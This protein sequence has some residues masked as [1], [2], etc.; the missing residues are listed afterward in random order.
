MVGTPWQDLTDFKCSKIFLIF[1]ISF[2]LPDS[3]S[4]TLYL[5]CQ[6]H[7]FLFLL[8]LILFLQFSS[9]CQ[10]PTLFCFHSG[11]LYLTASTITQR[12]TPFLYFST[13]TQAY[14]LSI[15]LIS[16]ILIQK[17]WLS[18]SCFLYFYLKIN[19]LLPLQYLLISS[20]SLLSLFS[21][22]DFLQPLPFLLKHSFFCLIHSDWNVLYLFLLPPLLPLKSSLS[23]YFGLYN[24]KCPLII[25]YRYIW[26]W[27]NNLIC[28]VICTMVNEAC[29][30]DIQCVW[31]KRKYYSYLDLLSF[32][33]FLPFSIPINWTL[34]FFHFPFLSFTISPFH[35]LLS[36]FYSA[37]TSPLIQTILDNLEM[38]WWWLQYFKHG[39]FS[40]LQWL[41]HVIFA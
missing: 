37:L 33:F 35:S 40:W 6:M 18:F 24:G 41:F 25:F 20:F 11:T 13:F 31:I 30:T 28:Y 39:C 9:F 29:S 1:T 10:F 5:L 17:R 21:L 4:I 27:K 14:S 7:L 32:I 12:F 34:F 3:F 15:F 26:L 2:K 23:P 8:F 19:F 16:S 38:Q 36:T 22:K